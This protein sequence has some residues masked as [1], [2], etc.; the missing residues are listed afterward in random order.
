MSV[1]GDRRTEIST[2]C[3]LV[4]R[5]VLAADSDCVEDGVPTD[6]LIEV[7]VDPVEYVMLVSILLLS[8]FSITLRISITLQ[9][10]DNVIYC[11]DGFNMAFTL[12][13]AHQ[14]M[15]NVLFLSHPI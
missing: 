10:T 13:P 11:K 1:N 4:D 2:D 5:G 9:Y 7:G 6:D 3:D 12:V 14:K 15:H 8:L